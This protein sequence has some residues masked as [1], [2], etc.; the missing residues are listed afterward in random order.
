MSLSPR[1]LA[2]RRTGLTATDLVVL[3]G[4]DPYRTPHDV[5]AD[6]LGIA[7]PS[8]ETEPQSLGNELEPIVIRRLA[9][10]RGLYTI[11]RR[12]MTVRRKDKPLHLATPDAFFALAPRGSVEALGQVKVVGVGSARAWWPSGVVTGLPDRVFV[13]CAW[14]LGVTGLPVDYVGALV[15]GTEIRTYAVERDADLEEL[16]GELEDLAAKWW[17]D[18]VVARVPPALDGSE[19]AARM[20][21]ALYPR[22]RGPRRKAGPLTEQAA[23]EYFDAKRA[24]LEAER[25][26]ETAKQQLIDYCGEAVGILGDGWRLAYDYR[27]AYAVTPRPYV[28]KAH[29]HFDL[30]PGPPA[31]RV[32]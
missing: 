16:L 26:L 15:G 23:R 9:E 8:A 22:P 30:R 24:A 1:Q 32:A 12:M 4:L 20:L 18:H 3:S 19:G 10:K 5:W 17:R 29:R 14:E 7:V 21:R 2:L 25:Q 13:Q 6:K 11:P 27:R 28:V 31:R